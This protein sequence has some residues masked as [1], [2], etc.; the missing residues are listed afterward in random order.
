MAKARRDPLLRGLGWKVRQLRESKGWTQEA[1][2]GRASLDRSYVAGIEAGLRNPSTKA[3][4]KLA[5]ALGVTI[6]SLFE[7]VD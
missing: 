4:A 2:A 6:S 3:L 5:R 7:A 1:L